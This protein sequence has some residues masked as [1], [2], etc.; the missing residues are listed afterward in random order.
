MKSFS[1]IA[2]AVALAAVLAL[3]SCSGL[4]ASFWIGSTRSSSYYT[5]RPPYAYI[6]GHTFYVYR[7]TVRHYVVYRGA[8]YYV[9]IYDN[10]RVSAPR[11]LVIRLR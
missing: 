7:E 4:A 6:E 9:T 8:T 11:A 1:G 5:Y 10:C 2:V 3:S